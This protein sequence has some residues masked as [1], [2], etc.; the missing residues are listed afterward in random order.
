MGRGGGFGVLMTY[1]QWRSSDGLA[2]PSKNSCEIRQNNRRGDGW[3]D[4]RRDGWGAGWRC[5]AEWICSSWG[6]AF[7]WRGRLEWTPP[8]SAPPHCRYHHF[9]QPSISNTTRAPERRSEGGREGREE[10]LSGPRSQSL[11]L[12]L[13]TKCGG[14]PEKWVV[15]VLSSV[16]WQNIGYVETPNPFHP[17]PPTTTQTHPTTPTVHPF[18]PPL[19]EE[20]AQQKDPHLHPLACPADKLYINATTCLCAHTVQLAGHRG[21]RTSLS[22]WEMVKQVSLDHR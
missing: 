5:L 17:L 11:V 21:R 20:V 10:V 19:P 16:P 18:A 13:N 12:F 6:F 2:R 1:L 15:F 8:S 22:P 4:G 9:H 7:E 3:S 14:G